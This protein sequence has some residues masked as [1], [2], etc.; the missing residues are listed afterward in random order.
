MIWNF[1]LGVALVI[2]AICGFIFVNPH[3]PDYVLSDNTG[4][5]ATSTV[6]FFPIAF[7]IGILAVGIAI[8][9]VS[10]RRVEM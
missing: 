1:I 5:V 6:R 8:I 7:E 10:C 3:I 4:P 2:L 9:Y